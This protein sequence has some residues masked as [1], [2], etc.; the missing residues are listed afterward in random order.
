MAGT[1]VHLVVDE[2]VE[3]VQLEEA[4]LADEVV[5]DGLEALQHDLLH[6]SLP[7]QETKSDCHKLALSLT[8]NIPWYTMVKHRGVSKQVNHGKP[9]CDIH[10]HIQYMT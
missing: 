9:W 2:E 1:H 5:A 4:D 7:T 3:A 6:P 10:Y 8:K